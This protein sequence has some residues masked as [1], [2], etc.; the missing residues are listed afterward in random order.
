MSKL[1]VHRL[2]FEKTFTGTFLLLA[3]DP[4][5]GTL[6]EVEPDDFMDDRLAQIWR[7]TASLIIGRQ[8]WDNGGELVARIVCK[9]A[10]AEWAIELLAECVALGQ[11]GTCKMP[12]TAVAHQMSRELFRHRL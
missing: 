9:L 1:T 2:K 6:F 10:H 12:A 7:A 5:L 8:D 4:P 11:A 3:S